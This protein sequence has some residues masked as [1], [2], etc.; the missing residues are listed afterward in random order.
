MNS[1]PGRPSSRSKPNT[2]PPSSATR[3]LPNSPK[4]SL[5]NSQRGSREPCVKHRFGRSSIKIYD[6]FA[7]VLRIETTTNDISAVKHYR[8]SLPPRRRGWNI[9]RARQPA[10]L[11]PSERPSTASTTCVRS[12]SVAIVAIS[13]TSPVW[14]TSR[15]ASGRSTVS[16]N[17][18]PS[19]AATSRAATFSAATNGPCSRPCNVQASTSP[20]SADLLLRVAQCSPAT[21][22]RQRARLRHLGVIK[23]VTG[24]YRYYL[25]RAGRAAIAAGRRLTEHTIIPALA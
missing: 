5:V 25:T 21:L 2:S 23:R 24:T 16:P 15:L 20:A 10:A 6:K 13:N 19:K 4:R 1:F 7:L 14:T 18:V 11:P 17:P 8:K 12:C 3:S 9:G 22:T